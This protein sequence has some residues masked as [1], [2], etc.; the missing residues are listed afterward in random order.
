VLKEKLRKKEENE[1]LAKE[2]VQKKIERE[3]ASKLR[4]EERTKFYEKIDSYASLERICDIDLST[5]PN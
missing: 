2:R 3:A 1:R 5:L 4:K